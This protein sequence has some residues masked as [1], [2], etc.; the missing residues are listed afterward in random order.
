VQ[1][2]ECQERPAWVP[3]VCILAFPL[4]LLALAYK[5]TQRIVVT[6]D[7]IGPDRTRITSAG[8]A[9]RPVRKAFAELGG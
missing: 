4:G 7:E 1:V 3:W 5:D 2:F 9:R 8:L 6:F